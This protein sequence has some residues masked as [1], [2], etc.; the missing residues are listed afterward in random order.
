MQLFE[1]DRETVAGITRNQPEV[2]RL[3]DQHSGK[4]CAVRWIETAR[5]RLA[6]ATRRRQ[7][8]CGKAVCASGA[9]EKQR[10]LRGPAQSSGLEFIAR[11]IAQRAS[12]DVVPL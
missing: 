1:P 10:Q 8:V 5:E 6:L 7:R 2:L 9:V 4:R 11:L 12:V 3:T